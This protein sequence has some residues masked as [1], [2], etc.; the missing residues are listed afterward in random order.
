MRALFALIILL[1]ANSPAFPQNNRVVLTADMFQ[2]HQRIKLAP[3][4]GWLFQK[5]NNP[6]WA[7]PEIDISDWQSLKPLDLSKNMED[8]NGRIEGWFRL[9]FKLD[10]S[11]QD[12]PLSISRNLWA[13]TDI[14]LNGELVH[15]FGDTGDPY[16]AYNPYLKYPEP[17]D[18]E[19][20]KEYLLAVHF[21]DYETTFTQRELRL[22]PRY[23]ENLINLTGPAYIAR[24]TH[25][26]KMTH[27]FGTL[28]ISISFLLVFLFWFLVFLNPDQKIFKWIAGMT[29]LVFLSAI[30]SFI[31]F[32]LDLSYHA[33]K[34]RFLVTITIQPFATVFGLL[35]LEWLLKNKITLFTRTLIALLLVAN[36]VA[37]LFSISIPFGILFNIMLG[38]YV[39]LIYT[40]KNI[41][42]G[43]QWAVVGAMI[44]PIIAAAIYI[45][46]HKYSLDLYY[47]YEKPLNSILILGAPLFLL[48]YISMRFRETL[49]DVTESAEKVLKITE[50]KKEL[51]FNQ[52]VRLEK[53]VEE[54]TQELKKSLAD[55]QSTQEQLIQQEKLASLGQLTAG[56]AHEIKNPLNFV[57]NFA[58]LSVELVEE[59]KEELAGISDQLSSEDK[60]KVAEALEILADIEANLIKIHEHGLRADNTVKS[61]L[62]HS[63]SSSGTMEPTD[64]NALVKEYVNLSFHGMRAGKD[65]INVDIE[66]DLDESIK[67][68]PLIV[69]DFSR[70][71]INLCNNAFDA[72]R[73]KLADINYMPKLTVSTKA[74]KK[75]VV[76]T[77]EDNGS[78]IPEQSIDK[79]LQPFFT[80][81]KGTEGTGLGLSITN[82]IIKAHR[83]NLEIETVENEFT[84]FKISLT[85]KEK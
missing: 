28:S 14:Y 37:H 85:L 62:Q 75:L 60:E 22:K 59:T 8:E 83:G 27:I 77:V 33:E 56:I 43:A 79:I 4:D 51:L 71:I 19:I 9:V 81:K 12:I 1:A 66:I 47:E 45:V 48:A 24:V 10:S 58:D 55:L 82:D 17:L 67:S 35:I 72:M 74:T 15:S 21:V 25:D 65:P 69:E 50:E 80:T 41:I 6:E 76:M 57:N 18:L 23:L 34:L 68:V 78:G 46:I 64:L 30:G 61:M 84:R 44:V 26:I 13:A 36:L 29:T 53:Q 3:L 39:Y 70:V 42:S 73:T 54:R 38:Y 63:R 31:P 16:T 40:N 20:G 7:S 32:F 5:G 49:D 2:S 11:L 52:N